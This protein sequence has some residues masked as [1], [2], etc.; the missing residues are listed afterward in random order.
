MTN[1]ILTIVL[2]LFIGFSSYGQKS[3]GDD[4]YFVE[5]ID[6]DGNGHSIDN[7]ETYLS[8]RAISRRQ[9]YNI[10][11]DESDLPV[12]ESYVSAIA[13]TG[14]VVWARTKWK[15]GIVIKTN[16]EEVL[17]KI[18]KLDCVKNKA[19][20][21][22]KNNLKNEVYVSNSKLSIPSETLNYGMGEAQIKQMKCDFLHNSGY[23]GEGLVIAVLDAG[24]LNADRAKA[25]KPLWDNEQ[26]LGMHDVVN[27][28]NSNVLLEDMHGTAVLSFMGAKLDN[29]LIGSAP[30]AKYWLIRTE[31]NSKGVDNISEEYFWLIGAEMADSVGVDIIN[32]SLGYSRFVNDYMSYSYNDMNGQTAVSTMAAEKAIE[33]GILVVC[34]AGNDGDN[35]WRYISAP[36]DGIN[37][38]TVGAV[39]LEGNIASFSSVGPT[40]DGRIKPDVVAAGVGVAY[41]NPYMFMPETV[42]RGNGTSFSGPLVAGA[43]ASLWGVNRKLSN[44]EII[45]IVKKSASFYDNQTYNYGYGIPDMEKAFKMMPP[46]DIDGLGEMNDEICIYPNP[47]KTEVKIK[48]NNLR[49]NDLKIYDVSGRMVMSVSISACEVSNLDVSSLKHGVYM[50]KAS[51]MDQYTYTQ[52][53]I[54][55]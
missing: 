33:K 32:S 52:K 14:A 4:L 12:S 35:D 31:D 5:F 24:F 15:N 22:Y 39:D 42:L 26:I 17:G 21:P 50:L 2:F 47:C 30:D 46:S 41:A 9:R 1:K 45:D 43:V 36:A 54:K 13:N 40:A 29:T 19:V 6:K 3:I 37:V 8:E 11:I 53:L 55:K 10:S 48:N 16:S 18:A 44:L 51:T 7:P 34:S 25:L 49:F 20:R 23:R 38:L 27:P 28:F